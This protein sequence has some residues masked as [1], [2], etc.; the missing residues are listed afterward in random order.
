LVSTGFFL[1]H[2]CPFMVY[3]PIAGGEPGYSNIG[4]SMAG[5]KQGMP[6]DPSCRR[7][8]A[9]LAIAF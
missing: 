2:A 9:I 1:V 7:F 4:V 8:M 6:G 5:V 3:F